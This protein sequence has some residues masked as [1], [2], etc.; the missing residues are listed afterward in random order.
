M[1][2]VRIKLG[3]VEKYICLDAEGK[4]NCWLCTNNYRQWDIKQR[5]GHYTLSVSIT[6][7]TKKSNA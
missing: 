1:V 3:T 4:E 7:F 2:M 6:L 5:I